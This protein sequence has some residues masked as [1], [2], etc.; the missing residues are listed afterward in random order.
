LTVQ[1]TIYLERTPLQERARTVNNALPGV[2]LF[3]SGVAAVMD[4]GLGS[5][6]MAY[7][8]LVVGAAIIRFA[9]RQIR[10]PEESGKVAWFDILG[11]W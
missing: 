6:L 7:V 1:T 2:V 4:H 5:S 11:E 9:I 3:L 10:N 8:S